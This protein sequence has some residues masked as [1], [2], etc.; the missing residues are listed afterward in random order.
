MGVVDGVGRRM[1]EETER[2]RKRERKSGILDVTG[3]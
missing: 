3:G 1:R 2:E